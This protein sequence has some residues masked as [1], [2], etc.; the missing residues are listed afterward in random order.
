M[1]RIQVVLN[2]LVWEWNY[3]LTIN[4]VNI[5][6]KSVEM[7]KFS[8]L[9][10]QKLALTKLGIYP[11]E[12][13]YTCS[14]YGILLILVAFLAS[15]LGF[16]Y[17][18]SSELAVVL[19][20]CMLIFAVSQSVG[21]FHC[22]AINMKNIQVVHFKLQESIDRIIAK[23]TIFRYF[24]GLW[25]FMLIFSVVPLFSIW[26]TKMRSKTHS[27]YFIA[28][29]SNVEKFQ[30]TSS[31]MHAFMFRPFW[32]LWPLH[33]STFAMEMRTP[34]SGCCHLMWYSRLIHTPPF[35]VGFWIGF[36]KVLAVLL[37]CWPWFWQQITLRA[38]AITLSQLAITS[39]CLWH[40]SV[41]MMN[42]VKVLRKDRKW[43]AKQRTNFNLQLKCTS[44]FMSK[45]PT[46]WNDKIDINEFLLFSW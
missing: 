31:P 46:L 32:S 42:Q 27:T 29:K 37:M 20:S 18:N 44:R 33:F 26:M 5:N 4:F 19:R 12:N 21:M 38:F 3:I 41:L 6:W 30:R 14:S 16:M 10:Y 24:I 34:R 15:G 2:N 7:K 45:K 43:G 28:A 35:W 25:Y 39:I 1:R 11:I 8:V 9:K 22:Y 13:S 36:S 17:E 40:C 23:G